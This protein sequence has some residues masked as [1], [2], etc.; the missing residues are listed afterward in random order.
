MRRLFFLLIIAA[1]ADVVSV[2]AQ[3]ETTVSF[4]RRTRQASMYNPAFVSPYRTSVGVPVPVLG[5]I[6]LNVNLRG[7]DI[8]TV[9]SAKSGEALDLDKLS[10]EINTASFGVNQFL[11]LD[12]INVQVP[13]KNYQ[14]GI[15]LTTRVSNFVEIDKTF[16]DFIVKGNGSFIGQSVDIKGLMVNSLAYTELGVSVAREFERFSVGARFKYL[17]GAGYLSSNDLRANYTIGANAPFETRV[18]VGGTVRAAGLVP[19]LLDTIDGQAVSPEEKNFAVSADKLT[20]NRGYAVDLGMTYWINPRLMVHGSILDL[21]YINWQSSA[22]QYKF[23]EVDVQFGGFSYEQLEDADFRQRY[24]D[25]L[26]ALF[27]TA[28]GSKEGFT[29]WLPARF[30][31]GAD[32]ELT[33]RD[34]VGLLLQGQYAAEQWRPAFTLAYSRQVG[35]NWDL[36]ANYSYF[37]GSFNNLGFGTAVKWGAAQIYFVQDNVLFYFFPESARNVSL[38]LGVNLVWGAPNARRTRVL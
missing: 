35:T 15:N 26:G 7:I 28:K 18:K 34:R 2:N 29:A 38:R 4:L 21:G 20:D 36:T 19:I 27:E 13:I 8:N 6:N 10:N 17:S 33:L 5:N 1:V 14:V 3:T 9:L 37:N 31:V 25:S 30:T 32:Y 24:L 16:F 12:I 23:K 11:G 22:Y